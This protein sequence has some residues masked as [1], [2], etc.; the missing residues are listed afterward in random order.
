MRRACLCGTTDYLFFRRLLGFEEGF[1]DAVRP[2]DR[3]GRTIGGA[4]PPRS[5][6]ARSS[7]DNAFFD[8]VGMTSAFQEQ[9]ATPFRNES[10]ASG[11]PCLG[12]SSSGVGG[13]VRPTCSSVAPICSSS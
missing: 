13:I 3:F 12:S 4:P 5:S 7:S 2:R 9:E 6:I 8:A 10:G 1:R 11:Y